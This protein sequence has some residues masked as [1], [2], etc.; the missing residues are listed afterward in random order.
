MYLCSRRK[1]K[2]QDHHTQTM[3]TSVNDKSADFKPT[4]DLKII[5]L[6]PSKVWGA[7]TPPAPLAYAGEQCAGIRTFELRHLGQSELVS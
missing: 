1:K 4:K 2:R 5:K 6:M 3:L 7:V